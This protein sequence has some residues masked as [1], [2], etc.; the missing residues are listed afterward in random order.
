MLQK[1]CF[2]TCLLKLGLI[3]MLV[4]RKLRWDVASERILDDPETG[5]LLSRKFRAP[6]KPAV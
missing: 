6:W 4:G 3:S 5:Q 2:S 1:R